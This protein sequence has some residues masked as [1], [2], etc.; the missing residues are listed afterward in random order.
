MTDTPTQ[1]LDPGTG[2]SSQAVYTFLM[3]TTSPEHRQLFIRGFT[4][5]NHFGLTDLE[6]QAE[7]L[8]ILANGHQYETQEMLSQMEGVVRKGLYEI[9]DSHKVT[10]DNE[11][12]LEAIVDVCECLWELTQTE[13]SESV[14]KALE[15]MEDNATLL[16]AAFELVGTRDAEDYLNDVWNADDSLLFNLRELHEKNIKQAEE[17]GD[18]R[19]VIEARKRISTYHRFLGTTGTRVYKLY[20]SGLVPGLSFSDYL[21]RFNNLFVTLENS[22]AAVEL[23]GFLLLSSD[24]KTNP[25]LAIDPHLENLFGD[26]NRSQD[27]RR[28]L[29]NVMVRYD[30]YLIS[31]PKTI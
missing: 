26:M 8:A 10:L 12:R 16:C 5:F 11:T 3:A 4:L 2:I 13:D 28:I 23:Y 25:L 17:V 29:Q 24:Y 21:E 27:V 9:L 6:F 19:L 7:E 20:G 31:Q 22:N 1:D 14:L 30:K 18:M 15:A